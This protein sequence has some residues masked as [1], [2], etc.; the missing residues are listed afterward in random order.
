MT[1]QR[2]LAHRQ[3]QAARYSED[4]DRGG[5]RAAAQEAVW[6]LAWIPYIMLTCQGMDLHQ[7]LDGSHTRYRTRA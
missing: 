5:E 1:G 7:K 6:S 3:Q 2:L 4:S